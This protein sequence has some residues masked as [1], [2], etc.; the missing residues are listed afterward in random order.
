M[1]IAPAA[2]STLAELAAP[3]G[4]SKGGEQD[5]ENDPATARLDASLSK[6]I[7]ILQRATL[8]SLEVSAGSRQ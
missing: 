1:E 6:P 3:A 2:A 8:Q 7:T 5:E 4:E